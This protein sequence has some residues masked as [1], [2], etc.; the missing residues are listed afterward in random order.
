[1]ERKYWDK[2]IQEILENHV[3]PI[4]E[5]NWVSELEKWR[6]DQRR[7]RMKSLSIIDVRKYYP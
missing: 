3:F 1:M 2:A 5:V 6:K 4:Y 7:K